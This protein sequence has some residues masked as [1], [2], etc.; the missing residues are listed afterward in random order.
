MRDLAGM[1][2]LS[3]GGSNY[4]RRRSRKKRPTAAAVGLGFGRDIVETTQPL[5]ENSQQKFHSVQNKKEIG[6]EILTPEVKLQG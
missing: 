1:R 5:D 2:D 6:S 3:G 4:L